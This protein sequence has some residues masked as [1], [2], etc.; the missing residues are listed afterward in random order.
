MSSDLRL[1]QTLED[2]ATYSHKALWQLP[3]SERHVLAADIRHTLDAVLRLVVRAAKRYHKKTTLQDLDIE[4]ELLR[5]QIRKAYNLGYINARR[6]E[7][8]VKQ[9]DEVGRMVGGWIRSQA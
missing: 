8:W 9:V 5:H 2:L 4:V 3:K 1:L 7:V 6:Y